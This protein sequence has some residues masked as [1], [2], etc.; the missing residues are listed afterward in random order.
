MGTW[1]ILMD[2]PQKCTKEESRFEGSFQTETFKKQ[3]VNLLMLE[4]NQKMYV[5][6]ICGWS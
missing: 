1:A 4:N 5:Q 2:N 6:F 3:T